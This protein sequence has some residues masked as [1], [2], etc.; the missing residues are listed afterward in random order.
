MRKRKPRA[1]A[2]TCK[3]VVDVLLKLEPAQYISFNGRVE[4][5]N[6]WPTNKIQKL[7][8]EITA[9]YQGT[10]PGNQEDIYQ[11]T[12]EKDQRM[13]IVAR[14]CDC[15]SIH[16][17]RDSLIEPR[18]EIREARKTEPIRIYPHQITYHPF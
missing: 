11:F 13:F 3:E 4:N 16:L 7:E 8:G 9:E 12:N 6:P 1:T 15:I 18:V 2:H 17:S 14:H 10:T 5:P